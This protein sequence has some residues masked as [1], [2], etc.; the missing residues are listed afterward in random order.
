MDFVKGLQRSERK[1]T[2]IVIV[3]RF[4]KYKHFI[5]LPHPFLA[6]D[7]THLFPDHFYRFYGL[8]VTIIIDRD[9]IFTSFF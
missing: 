3:D 1:D 8:P 2:I 7:I 5:V 9:K 6:Q 4:I